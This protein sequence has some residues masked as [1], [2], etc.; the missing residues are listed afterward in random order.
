MRSQ[1][2]GQKYCQ[3]TA[4]AKIHI[5]AGHGKISVLLPHFYLISN[6][7]KSLDSKFRNIQISG[8]G[9]IVSKVDFK[10]R[11]LSK[12]LPRNSNSS[13]SKTARPK[14]KHVSTRHVADLWVSPLLRQL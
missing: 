2:V 7:P 4:N 11:H 14:D 12:Y 8:S 1:D 6:L 3:S 5:Q 10:R 9:L 13:Q